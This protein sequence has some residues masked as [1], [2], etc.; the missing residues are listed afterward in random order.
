MHQQLR[1]K[2]TGSGTSEGPGAMHVAP[3]ERDP[4]EVR[5]GEL[6]TLLER[7]AAAGFDLRIAGGISIEG[8]GELVL[9]VDDDEMDRLEQE[10][11]GAYR[12]RR[13]EVQFRELEDSPGALAGFIRDLAGMGLFVNEI[14][15]GTARDGRVPVQVTTIRRA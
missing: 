2:A 8:P 14:F 13:L 12:V 9:A 4:L 15:V 3:A 11:A 5:P 10:L 6:A 7:V 1:V